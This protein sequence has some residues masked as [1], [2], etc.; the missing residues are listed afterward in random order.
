MDSIGRSSGR[1]RDS[2]FVGAVLERKLFNNNNLKMGISARGGPEPH[3]RVLFSAIFHG[4][5]LG[6]S[7]R[8]ENYGIERKQNCSQL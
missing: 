7:I 2:E 1:G 6:F 4:F 5:S 8:M 3:F